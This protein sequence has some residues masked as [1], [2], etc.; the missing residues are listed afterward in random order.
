MAVPAA[1]LGLGSTL[2]FAKLMAR[3]WGGAR[4]V[5]GFKM[6]D[7]LAVGVRSQGDH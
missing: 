4:Q 3:T 7:A 6:I 2:L 1:G 5:V